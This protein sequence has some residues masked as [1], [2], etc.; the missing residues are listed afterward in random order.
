M[1]DLASRPFILV[2]TLQEL[3][4]VGVKVVWGSPSD[5]GSKVEGSFDT[6][7]DNNGKDLDAVQ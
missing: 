4:S 2:W 5:V 6:V 7:I 1:Q 3:R